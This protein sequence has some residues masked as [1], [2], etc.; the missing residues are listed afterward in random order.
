M[1]DLTPENQTRLIAMLER[2]SVPVTECGCWIWLGHILSK[3]YGE[4]EFRGV[5]IRAHR[6]SWL[7]YRGPIPDGLFVCHHCDMRP[8]INPDHLFLG[9]NLDNMRDCAKKS[10]IRS[11]MLRGEDS[12]KAKLT[13]SQVELIRADSRSTYLLAAAFGVS[14]NTIN[15]IKRG[16]TWRSP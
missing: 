4:I 7:A 15:S 9:T 5:K 3:G 6:A 13:A 2:N 16:T 12:P 14:K 11:G 10:R 8:C 1:I